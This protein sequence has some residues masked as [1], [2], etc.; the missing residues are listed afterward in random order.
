VVE[1]SYDEVMQVIHAVNEHLNA[2]GCAEW[3]TAIQIQ[4]R[5]GNSITSDEKV[6]KFR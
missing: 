5:S 3:I 1:G 6:E 2:K 4:I